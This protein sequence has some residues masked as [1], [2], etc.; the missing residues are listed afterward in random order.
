MTSGQ[1]RSRGALVR[2]IVRKADLSVIQKSG[3]R[4]S[5][6]QHIAAWHKAT[7]RGRD[8]RSP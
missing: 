6:G 4:L 7:G 3:E 1:E 2:G 8:A 5:A